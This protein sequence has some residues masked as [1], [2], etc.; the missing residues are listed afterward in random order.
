[1]ACDGAPAGWRDVFETEIREVFKAKDDWTLTQVDDL[2]N[3]N[4]AKDRGWKQFK[5]KAKVR[6]EC[7][8]C[9]HVWTSVRGLVSFHYRLKETGEI[10]M[11]LLRQKCHSCKDDF[12]SP[13]WYREEKVKVMQNLQEKIEEK[14]YTTSGGPR[15][16]NLGQRS[17]NM[18]SKHETDLCEACQEGIC[19]Q[20]GSVELN[21]LGYD[22]DTNDDDY[23]EEPD[24]HD[25]YWDDH[26][27]SYD[28]DDRYSEADYRDLYEDQYDPY[29]DQYDDDLYEDRD[30]YD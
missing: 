24:C 2:P 13:G 19:S 20:A 8:R 25:D 12:E 3:I 16:L 27:E 22:E 17:A 18:T 26:E 15:G 6:F 29:E 14:F 28:D 10:K 1:M 23:D 9:D 30:D 21:D 7:G 4:Q 5:D 11:W